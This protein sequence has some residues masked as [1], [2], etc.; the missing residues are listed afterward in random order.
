M[1]RR[2]LVNASDDRLEI[3]DAEDPRIEVAVPADD[4]ERVVIEDQLV[5]RV[6]LFDE[7]AEVA[8]LVVR[9]ELNRPTNVALAI[10][11][12]LEQLAEFVAIALRPPNVAAR[13]EDHQL[14]LFSTVFELPAMRDVAVD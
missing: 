9:V 6:V 14:G 8:F 12:T 1:D 10:R 2:R 11:R 4:V 7:D 3:V 5:Q 13:F